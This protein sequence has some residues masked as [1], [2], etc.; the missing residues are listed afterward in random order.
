MMCCP[1]PPR[2][3][4]H[5]AIPRSDN[6]ADPSTLRTNMCVPSPS[7]RLI[8]WTA[9]SGRICANKCS[10]SYY[11]VQNTVL[12]HVQLFRFTIGLFWTGSDLRCGLSF[13]T[14]Y[15]L[16]SYGSKYAYILLAWNHFIKRTNPEKLLHHMRSWNTPQSETVPPALACTWSSID[17]IS[18]RREF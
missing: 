18:H 8:S 5:P 6:C 17:P 12:T 15:I 3:P 10:S 14:L 16:S 2:A 11:S 7:L 13:D 1:P 4:G 9:L